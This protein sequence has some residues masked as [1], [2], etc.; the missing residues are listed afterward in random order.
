MIIELP[1]FPNYTRL[2]SE[3]P[4]KVYL[5]I[6]VFILAKFTEND[7]EKVDRIMELHEK[8]S[9]KADNADSK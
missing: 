2:L 7:H 9:A 5:C 6:N 1:R 4:W 8:Y 3:S